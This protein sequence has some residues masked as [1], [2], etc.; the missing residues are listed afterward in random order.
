MN[1][2]K[3]NLTAKV[4]VCVPVFNAEKTLHRCLDSV[5]TQDFTDWE[6]LIVNDGSSGCDKDGNK[7]KKIVKDFIK[8]HKIP[9]KKII[10]LEHGSN[11]GLLEAR[12]TLVE[13]AHADFIFMLDS[14]DCLLPGALKTLYEAECNSGADI[15]HAG[16]EVFYDE[17]Q[18]FDKTKMEECAQ[19]LLKKAN[20]I[21]KGEL[22][23]PEVF[24]NYLLEHN[25]VGFLWAKLIRRELYLQALSYIPFTRCVLAEDF[26]QYFFISFFAKKYLGLASP[27][28]RYTIDTGITSGQQIKELSRFEHICSTANVFTIIFTAINEAPEV[29]KLSLEQM[30]ALRLESRSYLVNNILQMKNFLAEELQEQARTLLCDYWGQD[31]VE[32]MEKSLND[33]ECKN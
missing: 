8:E 15:V 17:S 25:Q 14:D 5:W 2:I 21:F 28:Y 9:R 3:K 18:V 10:Y 7:C 16:A 12:R 30:E 24:N 26:L 6:L 27:V 13:A 33:M 20:N 1:F 31:F 32:T 4:S 23:G 19:R 29:F 22:C 11:L